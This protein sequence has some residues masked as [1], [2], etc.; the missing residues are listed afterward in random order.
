MEVV[1]EANGKADSYGKVRS[2][3][4]V[5]NFSCPSARRTRM[6]FWA[7]NFQYFCCSFWE[8]KLVIWQMQ[9]DCVISIVFN[10]R[11]D[12]WQQVGS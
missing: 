6:T 3:R 1:N 2:E 9:A 12:P 5:R 4:S 8:N 7:A 11:C 10:Y